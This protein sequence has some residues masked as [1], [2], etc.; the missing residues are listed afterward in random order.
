MT[1]VKLLFGFTQPV[2]RRTYAVTGVTLMA[3]KLGVDQLML[4]VATGRLWG[5]WEYLSLG[6][7]AGQL[8]MATIRALT[9]WALPLAAW[10]E[11]SVRP[12]ERLHRVTSRLAIAA[13]PEE[14]WPHLISFEPLAPPRELFFRLGIAS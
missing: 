1:Y 13:P 9:L 6:I 10:V 2:D 11:P 3:L 7:A 12:Q 8:P 4:Y 5:F 14:I